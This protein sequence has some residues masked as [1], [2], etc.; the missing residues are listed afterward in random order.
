MGDRATEN[1]VVPSMDV[2]TRLSI[3]VTLAPG[4][5]VPELESGLL[6]V[7]PVTLLDQSQN[8]RKGLELLGESLVAAPLDR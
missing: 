3:S 2:E 6:T 8:L 4:A 7:K 1:V 5:N